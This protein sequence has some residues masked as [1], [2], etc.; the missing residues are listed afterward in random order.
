MKYIKLHIKDEN[1]RSPKVK[2]APFRKQH[3]DVATIEKRNE[4][5]HVL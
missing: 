2:E 3:A 5:T 1:F 4:N